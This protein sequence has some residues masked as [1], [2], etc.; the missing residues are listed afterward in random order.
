MYLSWDL[1]FQALSLLFQLP[2]SEAALSHGFRLCWAADTL[3][4][5][6]QTLSF[7]SVTNLSHKPLFILHRSEELKFWSY[8]LLQ[9]PAD[10][11]VSSWWQ[12]RASIPQ[13]IYLDFEARSSSL[14][15]IVEFMHQSDL[16]H[17]P[18]LLFLHTDIY[19][20]TFRKNHYFC[21]IFFEG[22]ITL[23]DF[24]LSRY[25]LFSFCYKHLRW[26]SLR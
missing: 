22:N 13:D 4:P 10:W 15:I 25:L 21:F 2:Q 1:I 12:F 20:Y 26:K 24:P 19:I 9:N 17:I 14:H 8:C 6:F 18:H 23:N 7:G 16:H 11:Y 3:Q 5:F